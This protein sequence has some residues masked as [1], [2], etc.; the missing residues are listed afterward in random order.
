MRGF[1]IGYAR[2][3]R[4]SG[5]SGSYAKTGNVAA[6]LKGYKSAADQGSYSVSGQSAALSTGGG[7]AAP[8]SFGFDQQTPNQISINATHTRTLAAG[9]TGRVDYRV[10]GSSTW[11]DGGYLYRTRASQGA[12]ADAFAGWIVDLLP[13]TTYE[14]RIECIESGVTTYTTSTRATR[15]LPAEG[16]TAN[17]TA[18]TGNF[19]TVMAGAAAGD[20]IA[21]AAGTYSLSGFSW[22]SPGTS[23]SPVVIRGAGID[24]TILVDATGQVLTLTGSSYVTFEDMTI[25]GSQTDSG[26]D[27]SS[28]GVVF[29]SGGVPINA[30]FR[31]IKFDG[32]D[33]GVKVWAT[34]SIGLLVYDCDFVGNNTWDKTYTLNGGAVNLTW[35]DTGVHM[36]GDGNCVW[37]CTFSG[38]GDSCKLGYQDVWASRAC[39]FYRNWVKRAGDDGT[40][41][42]DEA[43][44][45]CAAYDNR[46]QNSGTVVS[47][48]GVSDGPVGFFRNVCANQTRGPWKFTS[49]C[50]G[51]RIWNNTIIAATKENDAATNQDFGQYASTNGGAN[52]NYD[53]D[54]RNNLLI[55][56]GANN[57]SSFGCTNQGTWTQ[58]HNA[59]YPNIGFQMHYQGSTYANLAAAQSGLTPRMVGDVIVTSD[60][61]A[62]PI[63]LGADYTT[64]YTGHLDARIT[65]GAAKNAGTAIAGVTDGF[66][67]A[68]PDIGAEISGRVTPAIG[69]ASNPYIPEWARNAASQTWV[70]VP[71]AATLDSIDPADTATWNPVFPSTPEWEA[72]LLRQAMI[73]DAWCGATYD[74]ATDQMWLG[75]GGGHGDYAGN[76]IY[77]CRF[78]EA[79]PRWRMVRPPSGAVGNTLTTND[80]Q[81][82]TGLYS[83]GRP[84][85]T[86][87][88]NRWVY[89]PGVGP[90]IAAHGATSWGGNAGKSWSLFFNETN[91]EALISSDSAGLIMTQVSGSGGCY[92]PS[93]HAIWWCPMG[94]TAIRRYDI[95]TSGGVNT[96]TM[97]AVG[98]AFSKSGYSS[99]C[100]LPGFDCLLVGVSDEGALGSWRVFDCVTGTLHTPTFS[101]TPAVAD[102][103][104]TQWRWAP[105][106]GA[107]CGWNNS[108]NT[109]LITKLT[110]GA[111]PRT[112]AWTVSTL[113][114]DGSNA[115]TPSAKT[116]HGTYGRF[117]YSPRMGGFI[118]F[119][120]TTGSTYFYKI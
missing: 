26:T 35:N 52:F 46:V 115:V 22:V 13:N 107:A 97:T 99:L 104:Q 57:V 12:T 94:T 117:A 72:N 43:S 65:S 66:S 17:K 71:V 60:P 105:S 31:R 2:A 85:A 32:C 82:S 41:E 4:V 30:T 55:Y 21:L 118:V 119:N 67:G 3:V 78:S 20:V 39:F 37:N 9:S 62:S 79:A 114:V 34:H 24:S 59:W 73:V 75:L 120:S 89:A 86:H 1:R 111:N 7:G 28:I 76:E 40:V 33:Q 83:D 54:Y 15:A 92:D 5:D 14:V 53:Y 48:D 96:G 112:D 11:I 116:S 108:S 10:N 68:A 47:F 29:G 91:G 56:R 102:Q 84:R 36:P 25:R 8:L 58:N 106:L 45:N 74:E 81:D 80:G 50:A 61:F 18:N 38:H 42:F 69:A 98:S 103:G 23:G 44:G 77:A 100:Y 93:R 19:S 101:G 88:T 87:T 110:P 70:T 113:P 90:V 95:P 63:T 64:E 6:L 109:T 51:A 49:G 27:A 16:E